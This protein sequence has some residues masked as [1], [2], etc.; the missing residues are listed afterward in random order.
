MKIM[1][2]AAFAIAL[3]APA[4]AEDKPAAGAGGSPEIQAEKQEFKKD[5][6]ADRAAYKE[7]LHEKRKA[8]RE[9]MKGLRQ[10]AKT[11]RQEKKADAAASAPAPK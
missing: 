4:R 11:Q 2:L 6:Q 7:K 1:L 9:K 3:V 10:K 8:H 5:V